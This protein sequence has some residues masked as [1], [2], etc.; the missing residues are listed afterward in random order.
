MPAL[1]SHVFYSAA[2]NFTVTAVSVLVIY[3]FDR[4]F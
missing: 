3:C 2:H 1:L 4:V